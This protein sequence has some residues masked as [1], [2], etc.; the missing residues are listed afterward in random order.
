M[1]F[2]LWVVLGLLAFSVIVTLGTDWLAARFR[3]AKPGWGRAPGPILASVIWIAL[4]AAVL[5]L[6][7]GL[8]VL[9]AGPPLDFL[10]FADVPQRIVVEAAIAGLFALILL[11]PKT[12]H[13][14]RSQ[15]A[16]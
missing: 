11:L 16:Q 5:V 4:I 3:H 15:P 6:L 2:D 12:R 8:A 7:R 14:F 1:S 13:H 9:L 10:R